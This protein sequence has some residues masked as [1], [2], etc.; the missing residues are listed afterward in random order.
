MFT[1]YSYVQIPQAWVWAHYI[2]TL[3]LMLPNHCDLNSCAGPEPQLKV[4]G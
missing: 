2:S 1:G 4:K 3:V